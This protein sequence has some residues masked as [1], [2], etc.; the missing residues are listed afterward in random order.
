LPGLRRP[1][2]AGGSW[3]QEPTSL[4]PFPSF[5]VPHSPSLSL[6]CTPIPNKPT[7]LLL[8]GPGDPPL[9]E[10]QTSLL[11]AGELLAFLQGRR[12]V[13]ILQLYK[14]WGDRGAAQQPVLRPFVL[15]LLQRA[16]ED[17]SVLL[18]PSAAPEGLGASLLLC[19]RQQPFKGWAEHLA[20]IGVQAAL[21]ADSPFYKVR[22]VEGAQSQAR[23]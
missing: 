10:E 16:A 20:K 2:D 14:G 23:E 22:W 18:I 5:R 8:T 13:C 11:S 9:S 4:A 3:L 21:V 7:F 17:K 12:G 15:Q 19:P 6:R 1:A